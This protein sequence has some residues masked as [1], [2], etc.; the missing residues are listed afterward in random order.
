M[1]SVEVVM[2]DV[3]NWRY[4]NGNRHYMHG[5]WYCNAFPSSNVEFGH[6]DDRMLWKEEFEEWMNENCPT[7]EYNLRF[8]NGNLMYTVYI[9]DETEA[10]MFQLRWV[11]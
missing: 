2:I 3:Y 4:E 10:S 11:K 8:N 6:V 9:K 7:S 5:G 1:V